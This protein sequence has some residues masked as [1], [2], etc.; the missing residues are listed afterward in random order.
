M[1][2]DEAAFQEYT[3]AALINEKAM[4]PEEALKTAKSLIK[5]WHIMKEDSKEFHSLLADMIYMKNDGFIMFRDNVK[6]K[7]KSLYEKLSST[8]PITG[9]EILVE[10][11]DFVNSLNAKINT[12]LKGLRPDNSK[13][14]TTRYS[15]NFTANI[16]GYGNVGC[17]IDRMYIGENGKIYIFNYKMTTQNSTKW[18]RNKDL[19]YTYEA[20]FIKR[21]LAA[22]GIPV[23]YKTSDGEIVDNVEIYNIPIVLS[24]NEE[25]DKIQSINFNNP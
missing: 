7:H 2:L 18:S 14:E 3:V 1:F 12:Q 23:E 24:Y 15:L 21:I 6:L 4:S 5:F 8:N 10:L 17:H 11:F 22:N 19:K 20:A 16:K 13:G 9:N 25:A